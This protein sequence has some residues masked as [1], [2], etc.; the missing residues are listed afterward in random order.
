M[1][2]LQ[3]R[4]FGGRNIEG[5]QRPLMLKDFLD[6]TDSMH[7]SRK[8]RRR[9]PGSG[10]CPTTMR[11]LLEMESE[12]KKMALQGSSIVSSKLA[13][14]TRFA[15]QKA[16]EVLV[17]ILPCSIC[18]PSRHV[19]GTTILQGHSATKSGLLQRMAL[20]SDSLKESFSGRLSAAL[21]TFSR[22][23]HH[24]K[25][26]TEIQVRVRDI[27]RWT[28][29]GDEEIM[30]SEYCDTNTLSQK[31]AHLQTPDRTLD[32]FSSSRTS[33]CTWSEYGQESDSASNL[34]SSSD[35]SVCSGRADGLKDDLHLLSYHSKKE[36]RVAAEETVK[37]EYLERPKSDIPIGSLGFNRAEGMAMSGGGLD[38][39]D[40]VD[41]HYSDGQEADVQQ[42]KRTGHGCAICDFERSHEKEQ[43]SPLSVLDF[44]FGDK[45]TAAFA[46]NTPNVRRTKQQ[47]PQNETAAKIDPIDLNKRFASSIFEFPIEESEDF[48]EYYDGNC[49][50][51]LDNL[52]QIEDVDEYITEVLNGYMTGKRHWG[53]FGSLIID[54]FREESSSESQPNVDQLVKAVTGRVKEWL[55]KD[56]EMDEN[57]EVLKEEDINRYWMDFGIVDEMAAEMEV[58]V[59]RFLVDEL[60]FDVMDSKT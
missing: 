13:M 45:V 20:G 56:N 31:E 21:R 4:E 57:S 29:F 39:L 27:M 41:T 54:V 35:S 5:R 19:H 44:P 8:R 53:S 25:R 22:R 34:H 38:S 32:S 23:S 49:G 43:F 18:T 50:D 7:V 6:D 33:S 42:L 60:L 48:T 1:A 24:N 14:S 26:E 51:Y 55:L 10:E 3:K 58:A 37:L 12:N 46:E 59:L 16:S 40:T 28:S 47:L 52:V 36:D 11:Y 17:K 30:Y 15:F 2:G 9:R